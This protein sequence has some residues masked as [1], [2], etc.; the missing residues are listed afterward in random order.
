MYCAWS[1]CCGWQLFICRHSLRHTLSG[2]VVAWVTL[3]YG[4]SYICMHT[5]ECTHKQMH[6]G[7]I[8]HLH[9]NGLVQKGHSSRTSWTTACLLTLSFSFSFSQSNI[10]YSTSQKSANRLYT[11]CSQNTDTSL[12]F[13]RMVTAPLKV[14]DSLL[15]IF[16]CLKYWVLFL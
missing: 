4:K 9:R 15:K 13:N 7:V 8:W 12:D 14:M 2:C 3:N 1:S 10:F 6:T 16:Y 5:H 11:T